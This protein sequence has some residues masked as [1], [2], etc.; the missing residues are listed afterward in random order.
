[1][2]SRADELGFRG[3]SAAELHISDPASSS[4]ERLQPL[5]EIFIGT[6]AWGFGGFGDDRLGFGNRGSLGF[7]VNGHI[8]VCGVDAGMTEIRAEIAPDFRTP[9]IVQ[10]NRQILGIFHRGGGGP[11]PVRFL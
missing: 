4:S 10:L 5:K 8:L 6:P 9:D 3:F 2:E 11:K 1:V 7:K